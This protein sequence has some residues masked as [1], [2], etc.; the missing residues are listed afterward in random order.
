[1]TNPE[2]HPLFQL[3]EDRDVK[4]WRF[5]DFTK[6]VELLQSS[7]L[8]FARADLLGDPFEGSISRL[9]INDR[10]YRAEKF[11]QEIQG[12]KSAVVQ[13][14]GFDG[15]L[16]DSIEADSYTLKWD[17][18][19][20]FISC[21]HMNP[22]ESSAMWQ[23]YAPSGQGVAIQSTYRK[24]R[25]SLPDKVYV[26]EVQ[27]I[28]YETDFIDLK[29]SFSPFLC[30][31]KS[32]SHESELRALYSNPP[33]YLRKDEKNGQEI[34]AAAHHERNTEAGTSFDIDIN[35]LIENIYVSPL[36]E[37]WYAKLVETITKNYDC[38]VPV[39]QSSL[40]AKPRF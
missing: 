32:F 17:A 29:N 23:L 5:M 9:S 14:A 21:W 7:Q 39:K 13:L 10:K 3:P 38:I 1:M 8:F 15:K 19:W 36:A 28:C 25:K 18:E 40:D 2:D 31:R 33:Y 6:F 20:M 16:W 12:V 34:R 37:P 11:G 30:K 22:V 4:I 26:G 35:Q 27:Y 24:L